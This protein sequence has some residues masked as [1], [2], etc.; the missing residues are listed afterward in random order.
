MLSRYL[1]KII[2]FWYLMNK[3]DKTSFIYSKECSLL[4]MDSTPYIGVYSD[5]YSFVNQR[6][7]FFIDQST[8]YKKQIRQ[9]LPEKLIYAIEDLDNRNIPVEYMLSN[10]DGTFFYDKFIKSHS[11]QMLRVNIVCHPYIF[12]D[13]TNLKK[14]HF[15]FAYICVYKSNL[16]DSI[17]DSM[18]EVYII[19]I[20]LV[21]ELIVKK[22]F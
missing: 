12:F 14:D 10:Y 7:S 6:K 17:N 22:Y 9:T 19:K 13:L 15:T 18:E 16:N 3:N 5:N 21:S 11:N 20:S 8:F 4:A 2:I 1:I